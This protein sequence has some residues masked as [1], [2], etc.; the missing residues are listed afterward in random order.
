MKKNRAKCTLFSLKMHFCLYFV[1]NMGHFTGF[2]GIGLEEDVCKVLA[3]QH[4]TPA[5]QYRRKAC[6]SVVVCLIVCAYS[7]TW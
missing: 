6:A 4:L 2:L 5:V 3:K 1:L 7:S